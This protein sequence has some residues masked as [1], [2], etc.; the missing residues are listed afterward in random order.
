MFTPIMEKQL[1]IPF[2][3]YEQIDVKDSLDRK[4][5]ILE[6]ILGEF[7]NG[8]GPEKAKF[9]FRD[10]NYSQRTYVHQQGISVLRIAN[11]KKVTWEENFETKTMDN[12]PSSLV[13]IDNRKDRQVIAIEK[14][15]TSFK[16]TD[17]LANIIQ[18]T[19]RKKLAQHRLSV[20]IRG[21]YHYAQ[22]W[23]VV[24]VSMKLN[25]IESVTFPFPY[26]N[27]P[28]LTDMVGEYFADLARRTNS[29]P[30]LELKGQSGES[31]SV[32]KEDAFMINA[33]KACAA[34]GRPIL[35]KPKGSQR[36]K[37]GV[38][39]PVIEELSDVLLVDLD[40]QELFN[41]KFE[42]ITDFL[43]KIKLVY[44]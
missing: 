28:Q 41:S 22:F 24:D 32:S 2:E 10:D 8:E 44:E 29:E 9:T 31:V 13:I 37:I 15:E 42:G 17:K 36:R 34:S 20:D 26:P 33:I 30:T 27:L 25:G 14:K 1:E 12:H 40:K 38:E 39:C 18:E 16:K 21:K 4:Q 5:D 3:E 23:E 19:F 43:N 7:A 11:N 35:I 6:E